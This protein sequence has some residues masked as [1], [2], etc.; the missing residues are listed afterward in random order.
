[1]RLK[2]K[3]GD[4]IRTTKPMHCDTPMVRAGQYLHATLE[5]EAACREADELIKTGR[6]M[7]V[8][9]PREANGHE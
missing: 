4:T 8:E 7:I 2:T 1:M 9:E 5:S 6:W 3:I